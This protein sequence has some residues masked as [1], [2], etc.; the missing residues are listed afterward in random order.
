M[1]VF[2]FFFSKQLFKWCDPTAGQNHNATMIYNNATPTHLKKQHT[3]LQ[4]NPWLK[5]WTKMKFCYTAELVVSIDVDEG[6]GPSQSSA[7][8]WEAAWSRLQEMQECKWLKL[9]QTSIGAG[10]AAVE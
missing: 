1:P 9:A 6:R 3:N 8:R 5:P 4:T 2:L 10:R 7:G